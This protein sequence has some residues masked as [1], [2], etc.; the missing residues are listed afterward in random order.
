MYN[1]IL[2]MHSK[3]LTRLL[4]HGLLDVISLNLNKNIYKIQECKMNLY[5]NVL[6]HFRILGQGWDLAK[7]V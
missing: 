3:M 2:E 5:L 6:N 1:S 7:P 4:I